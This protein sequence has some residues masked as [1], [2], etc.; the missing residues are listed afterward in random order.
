MAESKATNMKVSATGGAGTNGQPA[1]YMANDFARDGDAGN[2][3]LQTS[4]IMNKSGVD[5]TPTSGA[6][7]RTAAAQGQPITRLDA[8]T[9]NPGQPV[10]AGA[11]IGDGPNQASLA[12]MAM[13]AAQNDQD[14][15]RLAAH[16]PVYNQI[17]EGPNASASFRNFTRWLNTQVSMSQGKQ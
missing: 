15:A 12:S 13:L 8:P 5:V 9:Q 10:T 3:Q 16:L 11:A 4:A 1:M 2:M 17:A 7:L 6:A 14:I